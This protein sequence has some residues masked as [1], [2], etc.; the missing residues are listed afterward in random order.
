MFE[1]HYSRGKLWDFITSHYNSISNKNYD[2]IT[3]EKD[4]KK[5]SDDSNIRLHKSDINEIEDEIENLN[6]STNAKVQMEI[7]PIM[8]EKNYEKYTNV[9][10]T[11]LL[12]KAQI[13]LQ[14]VNATL[15]ESNSVA[16]R[17]CE[18]DRLIN[19]QDNTS[20]LNFKNICQPKHYDEMSIN[21]NDILL[22]NDDTDKTIT[23]EKIPEKNVITSN[24]L[25][26]NITNIKS[27]YSST[28]SSLNNSYKNLNFEKKESINSSIDSLKTNNTYFALE[29]KLIDIRNQVEIN[30]YCISNNQQ[31]KYNTILMVSTKN[32]NM[33]IEQ[34]YWTIPENVIRLWTAEILLALEA[35]HQQDV[36][37]F[38]LK[39]DN[40]LL[41][42]NGHVQLTY[43]VP[44]HDINLLKYKY[45]YSSPELCT[46]SAMTP[47]TPATDIWSFGII[48][49]ELIVG[50]VCIDKNK[51]V[52]NIWH[53]IDYI[54]I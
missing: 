1:L 35:L 2:K 50:N 7:Y 3:T 52:L 29:N 28:N 26:Q 31:L 46:F 47:L 45:P 17:L 12:E 10:T 24:Y 53:K 34:E 5:V 36:I 30:N 51:T 14:S 16:N 42:D 15:K 25:S 44:R 49:Y 48:L 27:Q 22:E 38:D 21:V 32:N 33:D 37:V 4:I 9:S 54:I 11:Q 23:N 41:D 43:I 39:P 40:V 19:H 20:L 8:V 6:L 13:L 18:S